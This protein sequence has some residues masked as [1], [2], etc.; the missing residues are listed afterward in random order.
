MD[1]FRRP[2]SV[3]QE[4]LA[5]YGAIT[6]SAMEAYFPAAEPRRHLY[7]LLSD[8]P[9]RGGKMMRS[10]LCIAT[11]RAFGASVDDALQSAVAIEL[12]HN[13]LLIHD[14][15]EDESEQRRDRPTMHMEHGIPLA[16]NAGDALSLLSIRPLVD[17]IQ[18]MGPRMAL[19]ILRETERVAWESA[20]GQAMELGWR[21]DNCN[22]LTDADYLVMVL[23][24]TCWL[25][26]IHPSRVG[27]MIGTRG[28]INLDPF[29]RFGF[30]L[31]AAF[32][33]Q[34][35]VLNL[36]PDEDYGK[37][38]NGDIFEGK[39]T[40]M[41][42]HV[43]RTSPPSQRKALARMLDPDREARTPDQVAW[44]R[45]LMEEY[46][47]IEHA[48]GIAHGLAGAAL[49]EFATIFKGQAETRDTRFIKGLATWIFHRA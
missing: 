16:V 44:I 31:G 10:S 11:A 13:A 49:H 34:D 23:K 43:Y 3:V 37:E 46:G 35:D 32:Q 25:A 4:T 33:I 22:D 41:L 15:I 7:D 20:E 39:R 9:K 28:A 24:K 17:N 18:R 36:V 12:M 48:R 19:S 30:F 40:L 2:P 8:Y 47:S 38:P 14:D 5:E 27:A 21:R 26:S 45:R 29:I 1:D 6:R 42:N